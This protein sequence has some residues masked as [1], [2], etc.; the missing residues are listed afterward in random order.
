[1]KRWIMGRWRFLSRWVL[2]NK[3]ASLLG[4]P[5]A[6]LASLRE[7]LILSINEENFVWVERDFYRYAEGKQNA[8]Q[9]RLSSFILRK[10]HSQNDAEQALTYLGLAFSQ[11]KPQCLNNF[12]HTQ[13]NGILSV[14]YPCYTIVSRPFKKLNLKLQNKMFILLKRKKKKCRKR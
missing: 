12:H 2:V 14:P 10:K 3:K 9:K 4:P 11:K 6:C 1:M 7:C 13:Q 5:R 8:S